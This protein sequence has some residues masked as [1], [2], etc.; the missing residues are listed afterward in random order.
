MSSSQQS[1]PT[2][3]QIAVMCKQIRARRTC[4][5]PGVWVGE[6]I[7]KRVVSFMDRGLCRR[8]RE[9]AAEIDIDPSNQ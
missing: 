8:Q 9:R 4:D 6:D 3:E 5:L 1:D 7:P 2:P